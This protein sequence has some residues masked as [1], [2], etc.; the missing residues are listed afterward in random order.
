MKEKLS[1]ILIYIRKLFKSE[2]ESELVRTYSGQ[3]TVVAAF[4][5]VPF[6]SAAIL[7]LRK[8]NNEFVSF[9]ARQSLVI[10]LISIFALLFL[11]PFFKLIAAV[12]VTLLLSFG[13]YKALNGR[14]WYLPLV[15]DLGN[16]ID[17]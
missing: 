8:E 2:E 4:S 5:Y 6:V 3:D 7:V 16:S 13:V 15:T 12:L 17:L 11:P 14:K 1:S 10:L 9:H